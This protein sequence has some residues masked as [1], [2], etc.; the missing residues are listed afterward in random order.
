[1]MKTRYYRLLT[2]LF[3]LMALLMAACS[4]DSEVTTDQQQSLPEGMGRIRITICTPEANPNLTRAVNTETTWLVPDH[5]WEKLQSY[6][7]LICNSTDNTVVKIVSG[8]TTMGTASTSTDE[9]KYRQSAEIITEIPEGRYH[10]F[11]TAN[12][13]DGYAVGDVVDYQNATARFTNGY[14]ESN[15]PMTGKLT[16]TNG[17]L[18]TV[19]VTTGTEDAGTIVVWRVIGKMQFY[20]TNE[21]AEQIDILGVEVEPI[22]QASSNGPGIYLFSQ[23]D[24]TST[25]NLAAQDESTTKISKGITATWALHEDG[26]ISTPLDGTLS[27]TSLLTSAQLT[28]GSKLTATGTV[29]AE[30][31]AKTKL[32]KFKTGE[33]IV[34]IDE[35]SVI[36][37]TVTPK[38]GLPFKPTNLS[39]TASRV[40]TDGGKIAVVAGSTTLAEDQQPARYNGTGGNHEPPFITKYNYTLTNAATTDPFV[41]K[42]YLYGLNQQKEIAFS[43]IVIT[44]KVTDVELAMSGTKEILTLP[45]APGTGKKSGRED[46]GP[47]AYTPASAVT[48]AAN[49]GTGT[50]F[51]Y[52][53]ETDASFTTTQNQLSLRFKIRRG[54]TIEELRYGVTTHYADGSDGHNGFNVIRRNDWIHIPVVLT[55]WQFR[56]EPLAFVP[57]AGYPAKTVSSDGLTATFSTGG[58][59]ALQPF[60]K[61][62]N[63]GTWRDFGDSEIRNV[64][65][66]W[67]SHA[68]S[69]DMIATPFMYDP[70]TRSII[71]ELNNTLAK[72][73]YK[74]SVTV[75]AQFAGPKDP[76][77]GEIT[78]W[79]DYTFTFNV[80]LQK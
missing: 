80:I 42:I 3:V 61:K 1:M 48:L 66:T 41:I 18:K 52:V 16:N 76:N 27:E 38:N 25:N 19:T 49:G 46:V 75:S 17:T 51:F 39:F 28:Y 32:Q 8:T 67:R 14:S 53:N 24:L 68:G 72:G 63:D 73:T 7:I 77:T 30:D 11:A 22:N 62:Y 36:T 43:D 35:A 13:A 33:D 78:L 5:D 12:Y 10:I 4:S 40:G 15:I 21:S 9:S 56:V 45:P 58:M 34:D 55:D 74:T 29:T 71:G 2:P 59:I 70:V 26:T 54:G 37:L 44:G 31:E 50:L 47:V 20:F 65:I 69:E 6:R 60:V 23:D 57:I 64:S 79:Y